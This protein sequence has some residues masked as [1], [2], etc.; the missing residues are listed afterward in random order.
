[1]V[2]LS[3]LLIPALLALSTTANPA[4]LPVLELTPEIEHQHY[5]RA[6][7]ARQQKNAESASDI[8]SGAPCKPNLL[9]FARGTS[10][11]GNLGGTVGPALK[12]AINALAPGL[13]AFQ[14][15][16]YEATVDGANSGG[17]AGG[18]I[19][20]ALIDKASQQCPESKIFLSGYSQGAMVVRNGFQ[21]ASEEAR[22]K[23]GVSTLLSHCHPKLLRH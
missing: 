20:T 22:A 2:H 18:R 12:N 8:T 9:I 16:D 5:A 23:I 10:E 13:F 7:A 14:G 1:M 11:D 6:L 3:A 21:R 4:P 17:A 19:A 15:V